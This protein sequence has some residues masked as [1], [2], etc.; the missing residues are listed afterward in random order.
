MTCPRLIRAAFLAAVFSVPYGAQAQTV[1][2]AD[3][4]ATFGEPVT[5]SVTGKP[6]RASDAPAAITI[7]TRDEIERSPARDIPGL[8]KTYAGIDVNRWT[9]GQ[10]DVTVRGGVQTYNASLLVMVDGRQV[11]LDHYGMTNW[12]LISVPLE[13]V[14]QI[15]LVRGPASAIFGFNAASGVV[16]IITRSGD[17]ARL[18]ATAEGGNHGYYRFSAAGALPLADTLG[19]RLSAEKAREDE[20]AVPSYLYD[21]LKQGGP[22]TRES[23]SGTLTANPAPDTRIDV[24]GGYARDRQLE[25]V[26]SPIPGYIQSRTI[27]VGARISHDLGWGSLDGQVYSNW[28]DFANLLPAALPNVTI[29]VAQRLTNNV[30][31]AKT[32][33]LARIGQ[34]TTL[35][36]GGEY[37]SN[38]LKGPIVYSKEVGYDVWSGSAMLDAHATNRM[39][40]TGAIRLDHLSLL[41]KGSP[42]APVI[43]DPSLFDRSF[44]TMSF[45][46]AML[47]EVGANG[48]LRINGGRGYQSPSLLSL[49]IHVPAESLLSPLPIVES[50]NPLVRPTEVWSAEVGY[51]QRVANGLKLEGNLFYTRANGRAPLPNLPSTLVI[52]PTGTFALA[53]LFAN[54]ADVSSYG[55]EFSGTLSRGRW[56]ARTNYSWVHTDDGGF[57]DQGGVAYFLN[58]AAA[59]PR[60]KVNVDL[61]YDASSWFASIVGRYTSSSRQ[62][63]FLADGELTSIP[64]PSA[65]T[66]DARLGFRLTKGVRFDIA[67][68]NLTNVRAAAGSPIWADRRL[69]AGLHLAL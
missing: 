33:L 47:L 54:V 22:A 63:A 23:V 57:S 62:L 2:Y 53:G 59:S 32:S 28:L 18:D 48:Q 9:A 61:G 25:Y 6:Q 38:R 36:I 34:D 29:D 65:A 26:G 42:A 51:A 10:S 20:R 52:G 35:R 66:L 60:H 45:N 58:A 4:A 68:E 43:L 24:N 64:L 27:T 14:Q 7:I 30:T 44:T 1:D 46:A 55:A 13:E 37:R 17:R 40:L 69:R 5:T 39:T 56:K 19:L 8:L 12:N 49:G 31:V 67:G 3:L 16:N 21:P 41:Q 50:G 11:Y 15:E